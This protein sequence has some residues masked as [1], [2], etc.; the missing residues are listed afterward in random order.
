MVRQREAPRFE[1]G[2]PTPQRMAQMLCK[3]MKR[4]AAHIWSHLKSMPETLRGVTVTLW[5]CGVLMMIPSLLPGWKDEAGRPVAFR[6]LWS[7]GTGP[8]IMAC[9]FASVLIGTLI[10]RG[11]RWVRHAL[12]LGIVAAGLSGFFRQE[13]EDVPI[14]LVATAGGIAIFLGA[15]YLY[16]RPEVIAYFTRESAHAERII[17]NNR[18]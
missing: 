8:L 11:G 6:D 16:F 18:R 15:R 17:R 4:L 3:K 9:G 13:Y 2:L 14:G 1:I 10:Y 5:I 7:E 12:M